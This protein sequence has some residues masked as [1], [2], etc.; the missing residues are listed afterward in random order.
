MNV[1]SAPT[2]VQ[3]KLKSEGKNELKRIIYLQVN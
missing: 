2:Y 3:I 1:A